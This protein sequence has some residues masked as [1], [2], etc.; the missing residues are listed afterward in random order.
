MHAG[1]AIVYLFY[2]HSEE[3]NLV[4]VAPLGHQVGLFTVWIILI[5]K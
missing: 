5:F 4:S 2:P 3:I 1:R